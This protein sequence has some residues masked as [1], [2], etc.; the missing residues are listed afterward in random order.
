[1][2]TIARLC[3]AA[4]VLTALPLPPRRIGEGHS[5]AVSPKGDRVA[6]IAGGQVWWASLT[7]TAA[8]TQLIHARGGAGSLRWSPDGGRIAFVSDRGDHAF[9][10]LYDIA[11]KTLRFLDPS[12]DTDGEPAW[13]AD[14]KRIAFMRIPAGVG[15]LPFT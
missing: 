15:A 2:N 3:V 12:T 4:T 6:F 14:G 7:D 9:I 13:A 5:P 1:M 10:A 11:A 8:A